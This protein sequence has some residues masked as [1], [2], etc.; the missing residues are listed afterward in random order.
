M[1]FAY[2]C[3]CDCLWT[4][5]T[6]SPSQGKK[7]FVDAQEEFPMFQCVLITSMSCYWAWKE[8]GLAFFAPS[9]QVFLYIAEIP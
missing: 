9:L 5:C 2:L 7:V 8:P 6:Q 4:V 1:T 3:E